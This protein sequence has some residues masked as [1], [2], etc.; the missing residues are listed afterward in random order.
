MLRYEEIV[1]DI[2]ARIAKGEFQV[3]FPSYREL[4]RMYNASLRTVTHVFEAL[5]ARGII[6][7]RQ[8]VGAW[9]KKD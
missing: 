8:G 6:E 7:T 5:K 9:L 4:A 2:E 3:A 1:A